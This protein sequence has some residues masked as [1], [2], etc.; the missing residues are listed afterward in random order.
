MWHILNILLGDIE[1]LKV[2]HEIEITDWL[3]WAI[4]VVLPIRLL[5]RTKSWQHWLFFKPKQSHIFNGWYSKVNTIQ[6]TATDGKWTGP[7]L[8]ISCRMDE[9]FKGEILWNR[10]HTCGKSD[11]WV[12]KIPTTKLWEQKM[13]KL[14]TAGQY[15]PLVRETNPNF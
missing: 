3:G 13:T 11:L 2:W 5:R 10:M 4:S 7:T 8:S 12:E 14:S 9:S 6:K 15:I 1:K